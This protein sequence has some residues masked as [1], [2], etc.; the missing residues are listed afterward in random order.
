[1]T[2]HL[3]NARH[4]DPLSSQLAGEAIEASGQASVQRQIAL[5]AVK[6]HPG[7]TSREL[8]ELCP[9]DRYQLA[10]RLPEIAALKKGDLRHCTVGGILSVT[11]ELR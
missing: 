5:S 6:R 11:W 9:L 2:T 4:T 3:P 7:H 10:R 8:A 1:M